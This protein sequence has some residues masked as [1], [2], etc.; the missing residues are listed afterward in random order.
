MIAI[1]VAPVLT[2][3]YRALARDRQPAADLL[4]YDGAEQQARAR[5]DRAR[6]LSGDVSMDAT[7]AADEVA[8]ALLLNGRGWATETRRLSEETVKIKER[9]LGPNHADLAPSLINLG[10]VLT[11][12][13]DTTVRLRCCIAP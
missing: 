1:A 3:D 5:L 4:V 11:A 6:R 10:D 12:A 8:R 9:L 7:A 13:A 2:S